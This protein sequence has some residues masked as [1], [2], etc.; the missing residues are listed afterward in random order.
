MDTLSLTAFA[1]ITG[2]WFSMGTE[3]GQE[4]ER[5]PHRVCVDPFA[6]AVYPVTRAAYEAFI[7]VTNHEPPR[8]WSPN[9]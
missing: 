2:G 4:D 8:D 3:R 5:P 7:S 6:L 1:Q 9:T